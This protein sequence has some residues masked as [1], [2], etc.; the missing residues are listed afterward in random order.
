MKEVLIW[1]VMDLSILDAS[2]LLGF[3]QH[4]LCLVPS[5]K[6]V[7]FFLKIEQND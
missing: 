5:V 2:D 6:N 7:I 4:L 1:R 3:V